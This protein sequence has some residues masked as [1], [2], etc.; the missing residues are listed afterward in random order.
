[1]LLPGFENYTELVGDRAA[2]NAAL[3][4]APLLPQN[5]KHRSQAL[6]ELVHATLETL[7]MRS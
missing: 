5:L 3:D 7:D 2:R 6:F 4:S 1:M